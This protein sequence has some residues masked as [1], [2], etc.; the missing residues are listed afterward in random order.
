VLVLAFVL[1]ERA[2]RAPIVPSRLG[3]DRNRAGANTVLPLGTGMFA[4]FYLLTLYLQVVRGYSAMR[5]GLAALPFVAGV[6]VASAGLGPRLPGALPARVVIAAGMALCSGG[7][8]WYVVALT[9]T[10]NYYQ[11]MF[12]AMLAGGAGTGLTFVGCTVT[13]MRAVAPTTP[14]SPL[15]CSTPAC[16]PAPRSAWPRWPPPP[17]S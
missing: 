6:V 2:S 15:A 4:M 17:P 8:A 16:R 11:V 13:G 9:P 10:S 5:T 12:P 7:L 14:V 1:I 3:R